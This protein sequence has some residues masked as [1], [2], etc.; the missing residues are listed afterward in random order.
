MNQ[1]T[2]IIDGHRS[3]HTS[4]ASAFESVRYRLAAKIFWVELDNDL[5]EFCRIVFLLP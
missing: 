4:I 3:C 1:V 5:L 2:I